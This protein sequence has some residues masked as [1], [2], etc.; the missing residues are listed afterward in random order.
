MAYWLFPAYDELSNQMINIL[1]ACL[2]W[3]AYETNA[4]TPCLIWFEP[5]NKGYLIYAVDTNSLFYDKLRPQILSVGT[6]ANSPLNG[7]DTLAC[8]FV[9]QIKCDNLS[10]K[11]QGPYT[12]F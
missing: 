1:V 2:L 3:R 10:D 5:R 8:E 11:D 9:K 7:K 6:A 4:I 12:L